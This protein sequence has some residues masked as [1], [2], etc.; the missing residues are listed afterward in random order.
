M[1]Y[2]IETPENFNKANQ[3]VALYNANLIDEPGELHPTKA[4]ICVVQNPFFDAAGYCYSEKELSVFRHNDGRPR[5]WL[6]M[7]KDLVH[8]LTGYTET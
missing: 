8:K 4:I 3:L 6:L 7:D 5:S 1:G 2:Y